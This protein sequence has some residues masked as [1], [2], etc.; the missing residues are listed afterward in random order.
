VS[1]SESQ[2]ARRPLTAFELTRA[3]TLQ[4]LAVS[5][6]GFFGFAY[7]FGHVLAWIRGTALE[8]IVIAPSSPPTA[9]GWLAVSVGLLLCVVVPHE[10]LHG[11]FLARY[12]DSPD[13]GIG[14]SHFVLPYAYAGTSGAR[15]TRNQ[16]LIALLA[17][18]VVLTA[19]GIAVMVIVP[20]PVL[21]VPLAANA[22]GSIGDL[23]M[24]AVLYQY[25]ADVRVGDPPGDVRGFGIYGAHGQPLKRRPGMPLLARFL[26][27]CVGTLAMIGLYALGAVLLSLAVGSGDVVL[28]DP[29]SGWL[30]VRHDRLPDGTALLEVGDRALLGVAALGGV[31]W[32]AIVTVHRWLESE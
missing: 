23:W 27:G 13:Y 20:T 15:Y 16:L 21:I 19:V 7:G 6:I 2:T 26:S 1:R 4:W 8:P 28:G 3:V 14:V 18:F 22:A 17:P 32:T 31:T 10:L 11:V 24:A 29:E 9:L 5:A 30:L 12:G 25:P